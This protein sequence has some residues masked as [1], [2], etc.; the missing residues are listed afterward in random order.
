M[1]NN[2]Y[3]DLNVDL[4]FSSYLSSY[5]RPPPTPPQVKENGGLIKKHKCGKTLIG[6]R[7]KI[8]HLNGIIMPESMDKLKDELGGVCTLI[9]THH[10]T[11]G[12]KCGH[13]ASVIPQEKY[14]IVI[15]NN[16]WTHAAP[17]NPSAYLAATLGMGNAVAQGE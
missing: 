1:I 15:S 8:T 12:E 14:R 7:D 11:E 10:Y 3:I 17:A 13:L 2:L 16:A 9:K 4:R 5:Q 6:L